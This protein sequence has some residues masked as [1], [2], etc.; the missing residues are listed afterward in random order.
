[1]AA[2]YR[3]PGAFGKIGNLPHIVDSTWLG[4][5]NRGGLA[6]PA[7][8]REVAL[9]VAFSI[10]LI[11]V[12][13]IGAAM[14]GHTPVLDGGL[15]DTDD[16]MRL[17]RVEYLWRT[18]AWFD[19]VIPRIG[20]P[21]GL[22]LHWTRPMDILLLAGAGLASPFLGFKAALF[23]WGALVSPVLMVAA[24]GA[25]VWAAA[26]VVART[27]LP[28]VA[29]IFVAQPG[30]LAR[31][32]A[33]RPDHHGLLI[34]LFVLSL[35]FVLRVLADPGRR[36]DAIAAGL[37]GALAIWISIE[38]LVPAAAVIATFGLCWVLSDRH[39]LRPL[40]IYSAA[41]CAGLG[42]AL[43]VERGPLGLSV[44]END[45]ISI[46]HL[47]MFALNAA[48]WWVLSKTE[49]RGWHGDGV[50]RR[51]IWA[52]GAA[53]V[54]L[55]LLLSQFP[56][57]IA[58]PM[59]MGGDLYL[60]T[61]LPNI[62]EI[63]PLISIA[64][65][66]GDDSAGA[67]NGAIFWLGVALPAVPW[68]AYRL[69]QSRGAARRLW[70]LV[71]VTALAYVP[72]TFYQMRWASYAETI[73]VLPYADLA[74]AIF[75]RLSMRF[76]EQVL[77]L[78]RPFLFVAMCT[79]VF[80]PSAIADGPDGNGMLVQ[81]SRKTC[82][83]KELSSVLNDRNIV[84]RDPKTILALIDFGP[85]LLYRTRHS[86]LSIPNHRPQPGFAAGYRI[87]TA[88]DFAVSRRLLNE[89]GVGLVA[90]CEGSAESWFYDQEPGGRTLYRALSE[91]APPPFL[92][93]IPL[94][95]DTGGFRL[96]AVGPDS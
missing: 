4:G 89:N 90:I 82:P 7:N 84:G 8:D 9:A 58:N 59:E 26:P 28:L 23:W 37:I 45:K 52:G 71:A 49:A 83:I 24:L 42:L 62:S 19:A 55:L 94:P 1:L 57:L 75:A 66:H 16:Y 73:L 63:Q 6:H 78:L 5:G 54:S 20:P 96:F 33:G 40:V 65:L 25:A 12:I 61:H 39:L 31:F 53:V 47:A 69:R 13:Q 50:I 34:L 56:H 41:L 29:F 77:G 18:G 67:V 43:L 51:V 35:G 60:H 76:S 21:H 32:M 3:P 70:L 2:A 80:V 93:P 11:A 87:M 10:V 92:T 22:A 46:L 95:D 15:V 91:D 14:N 44:V 30:N 85:E 27:G 38:S 17:V 88:T 48:S 81:E 64:A 36:S 74:A 72:L 68:L 86:V 79:W